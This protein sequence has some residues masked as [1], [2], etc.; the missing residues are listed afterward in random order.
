M[1][2]KYREWKSDMKIAHMW[3]HCLD[4]KPLTLAKYK[5]QRRQYEKLQKMMTK[6][7]IRF[8]GSD[9]Y[10]EELGKLLY[11]KNWKKEMVIEPNR[12]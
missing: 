9:V 6:I 2:R 10:Y 5:S 12:M 3:G 11:G 7:R 8:K 1:S 4:C